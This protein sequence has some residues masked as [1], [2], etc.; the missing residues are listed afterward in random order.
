MRSD[1]MNKKAIEK[2]FKENDGILKMIP[3]F[4]PRRFGN[5]GK[6]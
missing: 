1:F 4:V 5:A 3:V 6:D 2:Y